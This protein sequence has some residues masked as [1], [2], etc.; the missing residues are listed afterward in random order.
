MKILDKYIVKTFATTFL[1]VFVILFLIF[2]LQTV[3]LFIAE[4]AGKDL[5]ILLILKFLLYKMPSLVPLALPLSVLLSSIMTFGDFAENYEFA[6][7]K[8]SGI[9]LK[10]A[11]HSST[12]FI[13]I[14]TIATFYFAN[15]IIPFAEY[16][17]VNFRKNIAQK[18]P[19]L[20]IVEGQFSTVGFYSIKVEKKKGENGNFL[21]GVTIHKKSTIGEGNKTVI[22]AK[23]GEL[24]S[25]ENTNLLKLVLHDGNYYEDVIPKNYADRNKYPFAKANFK[26]DVINIDLN[27]LN[28]VD[29]NDESVTN[30]DNMLN[31]NQLIYTLDSLNKNY[32]KEILSFSDNIYQRTGVNTT[33]KK[34]AIIN[35]I[36]SDV[37]QELNKQQ[38]IEIV[39]AAINTITSTNF[40]I[41]G[42]KMEIDFK[43]RIINSHLI[44]LNDKFVISFSC[45]LMFFIGAPLGAIIR[46]GGLGLPIVFAV[47][48]FII[49]HF[50]NTFGKKV[51]EEDGIHPFLGCWMSTMVLLPLAF[52]LTY[53]ATNDI[54]L[55]NLENI[56]MPIQKFFLK[57]IP[58]KKGD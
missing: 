29:I 4:L 11:L 42:S 5:D 57:F 15:N 8:S 51:A 49:F 24:V 9:S 27:K 32:K 34:N 54:G 17:F 12:I 33:I 2:I 16:K 7:M 14:L 44:S 10:R 22:K 45:I 56:L 55:F 48:I 25:N 39:N 23:T 37:L 26:T 38:K 28:N 36:N 52:L 35:T 13:L 50:I 43:K 1:T 40:S 41:D 6:A 3:W 31:I 18:K 30:T 20:A 21:E 19:A 47:L 53:R 58:S 46:K